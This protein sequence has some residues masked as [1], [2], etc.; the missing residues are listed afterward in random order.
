MIRLKDL[1]ERLGGTLVGDGE[2][3]ITGVAG[4]QSAGEGDITFLT[5]AA[6]LK[7]LPD[8]G[9]SA[10]VA[11][12]DAPPEALAGKN[13]VIVDNPGLAYVMVAE[14]FRKPATPLKGVH[15]LACVVEG[16]S[17]AEDASVG[18]YTYVGE[19]ARVHPGVVLYPFVYVGAGVEIGTDSTIYPH[20][21][22]YP[23]TYLG[24][25]VIV[26]AGAVL[27]ADGFGYVWDGKGHRK[28][29][30]L[31]VLRIGDDTEIGANTAI[32][33][34]SLDATVIGSD[35]KIDNMVQIGH[36]VAVGDHSILVSQVGIAGST[37]IGDSSVLAGQVGVAGHLHIGKGTK[38]SAQT[39]I[40]NSLPDGSFVSG[41]PA[42]DNREWLKSSAVFRRL[43]EMKKALAALERRLADLETRLGA[44][45]AP[46]RD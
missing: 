6:Y 45:P 2:T 15:P 24:K 14:T 25:R 11:G 20:V 22:L 36:N 30:Q 21:T 18:P 39:G 33:R 19:G 12:K 16:A 13:C 29:P 9:A 31:G 43:P 32:D 37:T 27:G 5:Q 38:A 26:H 44:E 4:I 17:I 8:C 40:P 7:F 28:I 41:Y 42:I 35:V 46:S 23:G 10:V 3:I 34:A 1:A